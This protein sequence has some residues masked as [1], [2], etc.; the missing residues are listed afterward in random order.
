MS[1]DPK[2][3]SDSAE[4]SE[5]TGKGYKHYL[6]YLKDNKNSKI[7]VWL[8]K[9]SDIY[10]EINKASPDLHDAQSI[11]IVAPDAVVADGALGKAVDLARMEW[12][13]AKL[14]S[15][16]PVELSERYNSRMARLNDE[17]HHKN[18]LFSDVSIVGF[19]KDKDSRM[20]R[21]LVTKDQDDCR[22]Q[23]FAV[24]PRTGVVVEVFHVTTR[25][26]LVALRRSV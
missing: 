8:G 26:C 13:K 7:S 21:L 1:K 11:G 4:S 17:Y 19:M 5:K 23:V 20:D 15:E 6:N 22:N 14:E 25:N 18:L 9:A 2:K 12:V 3:P 10:A 16:D 24:D